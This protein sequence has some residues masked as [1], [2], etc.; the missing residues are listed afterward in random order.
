MT[1]PRRIDPREVR[2]RLQAGDGLLLVCAYDSDAKFEQAR[3]EG[4]LPHSQLAARL[5]TLARD[6]ELVFYCG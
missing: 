5:P 4:A 2:R 3:I 1:Q 6:A